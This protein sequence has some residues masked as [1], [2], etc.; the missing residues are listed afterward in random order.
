MTV[1]NFALFSVGTISAT[2]E[3]ILK[4]LEL[5]SCLFEKVN[6]LN[7]HQEIRNGLSIKENITTDAR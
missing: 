5:I 3:D 1:R 7:T 2:T 6:P 4:E